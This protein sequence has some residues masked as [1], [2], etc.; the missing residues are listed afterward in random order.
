MVVGAP[1]ALFLFSGAHFLK[2][3]QKIC[4]FNPVSRDLSPLTEHRKDVFETVWGNTYSKAYLAIIIQK[5]SGSSA[6]SLEV[7]VEEVNTSLASFESELFSLG[8][9]SIDF[10]KP[11]KIG[12]PQDW[13]PEEKLAIVLEA[14]SLSD[15]ELGAFL[16]NKGL[17][18]VHASTKKMFQTTPI[19]S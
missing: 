10:L 19:M 11:T 9:E 4:D 3:Q 17:H 7:P 15:A 12:R 16:R 18:E 8:D 5:A 13:S 2:K 1:E 6:L 14:A